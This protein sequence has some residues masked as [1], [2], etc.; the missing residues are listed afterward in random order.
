[1]VT[2][3]PGRGPQPTGP[4]LPRHALASERLKGWG[5]CVMPKAIDGSGRCGRERLFGGC[6]KRVRRR[7][8]SAPEVIEVGVIPAMNRPSIS[9][10]ERLQIHKVV[11]AA[12]GDRGTVE[13]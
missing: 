1:M 10:D 6:G 11:D 2:R 8:Q 12:L 3:S 5:K 9:E 4:L 13:Y 7:R